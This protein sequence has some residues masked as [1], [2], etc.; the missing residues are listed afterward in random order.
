MESEQDT[1]SLL[2]Q[3][4]SSVNSMSTKLEEIND[5]TEALEVAFHGE[6]DAEPGS[7][8]PGSMLRNSGIFNTPNA[9][10]ISDRRK[11]RIELAGERLKKEKQEAVTKAP[12]V[13]LVHQRTEF[14]PPPTLSFSDF[15]TKGFLKICKS[16]EQHYDE[17][18]PAEVKT[19]ALLGTAVQHKVFNSLTIKAN[20]GKLPLEFSPFNLDKDALMKLDH[21]VVKKYLL[22]S[23]KTERQE[24]FVAE[25]LRTMRPESQNL[26][27]PAVFATLRTFQLEVWHTKYKDLLTMMVDVYQNMKNHDDSNVP[28][29]DGDKALE[30][31]GFIE[32]VFSLLPKAVRTWLFKSKTASERKYSKFEDLIEALRENE[33]GHYQISLKARETYMRSVQLI[34]DLNAIKPKDGNDQKPTMMRSSFIRRP[35]QDGR[36]NRVQ[37]IE[38]IEEEKSSE[39]SEEPIDLY[40]DYDSDNSQDS[41]SFYDEYRF[42][43]YGQDNLRAVTQWQGNGQSN[44]NAV[45]KPNE[46][47]PAPPNSR[48]G[49]GKNWLGTANGKDTDDKRKSVSFTNPR[50]PNRADGE[51][52]LV[53]PYKRKESLPPPCWYTLAWGKCTNKDCRLEHDEQKLIVLA[54]IAIYNAVRFLKKAGKKYM[55]TAVYKDGTKFADIQYVESVFSNP[56]PKLSQLEEGEPTSNSE[57]PNRVYGDIMGPDA[58]SRDLSRWPNWDEQLEESSENLRSIGSAAQKMHTTAILY[59]SKGGVIPVEDA[60]LD[61]GALNGSYVDEAWVSRYREELKDFIVK[62]KAK[63]TLADGVSKLEIS[64]ILQGVKI[65]FRDSNGSEHSLKLS[66]AV[67]PLS[68]PIIIGLPDLVECLPFMFERLEQARE[69]IRK[70]P[71]GL[72][73]LIQNEAIYTGL[74]LMMV[75]QENDLHISNIVYP[76]EEV[77][78]PDG[79]YAPFAPGTLPQ[80]A[81]E[82]AETPDISLHNDYLMSIVEETYK[83]RLEEYHSQRETLTDKEFAKAVPQFKE[84]MRD[85]AYRAF[86][87]PKHEGIRVPPIHLQLKEG[88]PDHYSPGQRP[89]HPNLMEPLKKHLQGMIDSGIMSVHKH[90]RYA[91]RIV[92]APKKTSPFIRVCGEYNMFVN[93]WLEVEACFIPNPYKELTRFKNG[94]YIIN[95]DLT[96]SFR[97]FKLDDQAAEFLGLMSP[98]GILRQNFLPEGIAPATSRLQSNMAKIFEDYTS[99]WLIHIFDNFAIIADTPN[100]LFDRFK[101]FIER[102]IEFNVGLQ[103]KKCEF[104]VTQTEFF[105]YIV[106]KEGY[107]LAASRKQGLLDIPFPQ[108]RGRQ[109]IKAMRSFIGFAQFF[110]DFVP[111][112]SILLAPL[113]DMIKENFDW[114]ETNWNVDYRKHFDEFKNKCAVCM[115]CYHPDPSLSWVHL[116]DACDLAVA[117]MLIQIRILPDGTVREELLGCVSKKL[118]DVAQRWEIIKKECYA[119]YFGVMAFSYYLRL[120]PFTILTDHRNLQWM[121]KSSSAIIIRWMQQLR[122]FPILAIK[123]I[124]GKLNQHADYLSREGAPLTLSDLE[125]VVVSEAEATGT[126]GEER[127]AP[128]VAPAEEIDFEVRKIEKVIDKVSPDKRELV[129]KWTKMLDQIHGGRSLHVGV[130][131]TWRRVQEHFPGSD[132]TFRRVAEYVANCAICQKYRLNNPHDRLQPEIKH[133]KS[134]GPRGATGIDKLEISPPDKHGHKYIYSMMN[135]GTG[136]AMGFATKTGTAEDAANAMVFWM[137]IFGLTS[138]WVSDPGSDFKSGTI[139]H[140][141]EYFG[142]R[143]QF[144]LVDRHESCGIEPLNREVVRYIRTI[145]AEEGL[146]DCWGEQK[147][148][149]VVF[150]S[151]NA[152]INSEHGVSPVEATFGSLDSEYF[153]K[154]ENYPIKETALNNEYVSELDR[155]VK[156]VRRGIEK[157]HTK[158]IEERTAKNKL[159]PRN[160]WQKGDLVFVDNNSRDNKIQAPKLGPYE[161]IKQTGNDVFVRDILTNETRTP[162]HVSRVSLFAGTLEKAKGLALRDRNEFVV[163][164]VVAFR[165]NPEIRTTV[166]LL[167]EFADGSIPWLTWNADLAKTA[168]YER[169][170][171]AEPMCTPLLHSAEEWKRLRRKINETVISEVGVGLKV[172]VELRYYSHTWYKDEVPFEDKY[173]VKYLVPME[174]GQWANKKHTKIRLIDEV[175]GNDFIVDHVFVRTF[176]YILDLSKLNVPYVLVTKEFRSRNKAI[177]FIAAADITAQRPACGLT[178]P[179]R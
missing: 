152:H 112:F 170:C 80:I 36:H 92:V 2:E 161:V 105:G 143:H 131:E 4:L 70:G 93:K 141:L 75:T 95:A 168:A 42:R 53:D 156:A 121:E 138:L 127:V 158:I 30:L 111:K 100:E 74:E 122:N 57:T 171:D 147:V 20:T 117:A 169:F 62:V 49:N 102:C 67:I 44:M 90:G 32:M 18:N 99:T 72:T 174:Y 38:S 61:S 165:G 52:K 6:E 86:V 68:T 150:A 146:H 69:E 23:V 163:K 149:G 66:L 3:I 114:D 120:K 154:F 35:P 64:E 172:Y 54:N 48:L 134:F 106:N 71:N 108:G 51:K 46:Y 37:V 79:L 132:I 137:S 13:L 59:N 58:Y 107:E 60:L 110:R 81:Q 22:E 96:H 34:A 16:V 83:E 164:R 10:A 84:Y 14:K 142:P 1:K 139:K 8:T 15:S 17:Q 55:N 40:R 21:S 136:M 176:G 85:V 26:S 94:M 12:G 119:I 130:K 118:T 178:Q 166:E 179:L 160:Y 47:N 89:V 7:I 77:N 11:S 151:I 97:Q 63:V 109:R 124:A 153:T 159:V 76:Q 115:R 50:V 91:T 128:Q 5:R 56:A 28:S 43:P 175:Y 29:S 148:I 145:V 123:H 116:Q 144:S 27:E 173:I 135:L 45:G 129:D 25:F 104:G 24:D 82:D 113:T 88:V 133:L 9:V 87:H 155:V 65:S 41:R 162:Y 167:V 126:R 78:L 103:M 101:L 125:R 177:H 33:E 157:H 140:L 73:R 39:N 19:F 98:L 31:K